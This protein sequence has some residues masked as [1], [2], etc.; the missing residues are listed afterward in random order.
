MHGLSMDY[1][2]HLFARL[3]NRTTWSLLVALALY[4]LV[5]VLAPG[6]PL[7]LLVEL[8]SSRDEELPAIFVRGSA[9]STVEILGPPLEHWC[10]IRAT[11]SFR[12]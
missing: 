1:C 6:G 3:P 4:D 10:R 11:S 8:A 9:H 5:V 12:R 2:C 7:K